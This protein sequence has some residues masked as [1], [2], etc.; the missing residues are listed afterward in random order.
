MT[1]QNFHQRPNLNNEGEEVNTDNASRKTHNN[2][3]RVEIE[4][5]NQGDNAGNPNVANN[6]DYNSEDDKA[7][8]NTRGARLPARRQRRAQK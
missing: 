2:L 4:E 7:L 1:K 6:E 3:F 5:N 8:L